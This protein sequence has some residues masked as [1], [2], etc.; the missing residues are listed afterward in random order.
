MLEGVKWYDDLTDHGREVMELLKDKE[1]WKGFIQPMGLPV[2]IS[3]N[4]QAGSP[5][6]I[7]FAGD[8]IVWRPDCLIEVS[9]D[10]SACETVKMLSWS[11]SWARDTD[12][13]L[14]QYGASK[15]LQKAFVPSVHAECFKG[16]LTIQTMPPQRMQRPKGLPDRAYDYNPDWMQV[17]KVEEANAVVIWL[18]YCQHEANQ[19]VSTWTTSWKDKSEFVGALRDRIHA[20]ATTANPKAIAE[21]FVVIPKKFLPQQFLDLETQIQQE[22]IFADLEN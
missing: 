8:G 6:T 12:Y 11:R 19:K 20:L 13:V 16:Y 2:H 3:K 21:E 4:D 15:E 17:S 18:K 1:M 9:H 7:A 5:E 10:W 14:I 22:A